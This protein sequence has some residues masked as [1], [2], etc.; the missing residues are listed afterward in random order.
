MRVIVFLLTALAAGLIQGVTGFG[1][2][3]V[4]MMSYPLY[5]PVPAAAAISTCVSVPLNVNMLLTYMCEVRWRKVLLPVMPYLALCSAAI[6]YSRQADP[7]LVKKLFGVLLILLAI[8]YLTPNRNRT[9]IKKPLGL[10][11]SIIYIAVSAVCDAFFGIGGPLMVLYFLNKTEGAKEYYGTISAFFLINGIYTT[12]YRFAG[13]ILALEHLPYIAMGIP[14]ILIGVILA[15]RL[16]S[17][18][19][20]GMIRKCTYVMIGIT[21]IINIVG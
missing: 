9:G 5:W 20:D 8:Y 2:G 12:V 1:S 7:V 11:V 18:L 21:G 4:Q 15:H 14:A 3:I 10:P 19:N 13:G 16:V 17:R 6:S